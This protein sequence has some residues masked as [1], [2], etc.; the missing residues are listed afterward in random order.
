[1]DKIIPSTKLRVVTVHK[2]KSLTCPRKYFWERVLNLESRRLKDPFWYGSLI[3]AG[4]EALIS[5][6]DPE[7][8]MRF[9][10]RDYRKR[11]VTTS[12]LEDEMKIQRRLISACIAQAKHH[13]KVKKMEMKVSQQQFKVRLK[14][15]CLWFCGTPDGFGTYCKK[16]VMFE[17][18]TASQITNSYI[19]ALRFDKQVYGYAYA[20][21]LAGNPVLP[22][23]CYCIFRKPQKW[24]KKNQTIDDFVK[25][26]EKDFADRRDFYYSFIELTLGKQTISE[27]GHDIETLAFELKEKYKRLRADGG[28]LDPHNWPRQESKCYKYGGCGFLQLCRNPK[29]W[30]VYLRLFQQRKMLY[31]D[32]KKE[33]QR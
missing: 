32:E 28:L 6:K 22:K 2:L 14:K 17:E 27:V 31:E 33:L 20:Q 16:P 25:D 29:K 21:Q 24:V 1:M 7:K 15:S 12:D 18:K 19:D 3:G 13:P 8:A 10:D 23:C 9:E 11:Y 30:Q 4:F 5:S 26:I